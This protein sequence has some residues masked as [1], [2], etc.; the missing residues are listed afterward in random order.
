ML[1]NLYSRSG[2][3]SIMTLVKTEAL[4][5][6][7]FLFYIPQ[8]ST[9]TILYVTSSLHTACPSTPCHLLS[10]YIENATGYFLSNTTM[11]FLPG[12]HTFNVIANVTSV[13]GFSMVRVSANTTT[14]V[15]SGLRCGGFYF[16]NVTSL[17]VTQ[18]SFVST[19]TPSPP[20]ICMTFNL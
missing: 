12:K 10:Q 6:V 20:R 1:H 18:L 8:H 19:A 11:I 16:D 14:I 9:A 17:N 15:C 3:Y 2:H 7:L 5:L 13:I 4:L